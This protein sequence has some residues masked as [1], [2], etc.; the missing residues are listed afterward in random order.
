MKP[1]IIF[2]DPQKATRDTL[3]AAFSVSGD[4]AAEGVTISTRT[5]PGS[6]DG[7]ALPYIQVRSD[8]RIRDAQLDGRAIMRVLVWHRDEGLAEE[9]AE[10]AEARLLASSGHEIRGFTPVA[11]PTPL[12]GGDRDTGL[13]L[14]FFTITARLRPSQLP[15]RSAP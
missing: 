11:G 8:G 7:R 1:V 4:P 9:L 14:S 5:L 12:P 2:P 3:R 10:L 15:E 13:P 6:D